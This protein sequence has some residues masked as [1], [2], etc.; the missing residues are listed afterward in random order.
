MHA[1]KKLIVGCAVFNIVVGGLGAFAGGVLVLMTAA[2]GSP[3]EAVVAVPLLVGGLMYAGAGACLLLPNQRAWVIGMAL[4]GAAI[5][6]GILWAAY[7]VFAFQRDGARIDPH[8]EEIM[9]FVILPA[10][11]VLVAIAELGLLWRLRPRA[12]S[13][14]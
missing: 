12:D 7:C 14:P 10:V 4:Q 3:G 1:K 2:M 11:C 5:L 6:L 9:M 8:D 13:Q